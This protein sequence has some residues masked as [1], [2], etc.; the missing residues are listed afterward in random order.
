MG[1]LN[2]LKNA[3]H[4]PTPRLDRISTSEMLV[5]KRM[6]LNYRPKEHED[7]ANILCEMGKVELARIQV[8]EKIKKIEN[9]V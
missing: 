6:D 2:L 9:V 8:R 3:M 7:K 4:I 5:K 1:S